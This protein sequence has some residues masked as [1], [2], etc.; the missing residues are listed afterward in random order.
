MPII[1]LAA[2]A[3]NNLATKAGWM[4]LKLPSSKDFHVALS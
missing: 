2:Q 4:T 3:G 1:G